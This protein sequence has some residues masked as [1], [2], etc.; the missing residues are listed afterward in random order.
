MRF[1]HPLLGSLAYGGAPADERRRAHGALAAS[2]T[3]GQGTESERRAWH[4]AAATL[5]PDEHVAGALAAAAERFAHRSGHLAAAY[6]YE[7]AAQLT[8]DPALRGAAADRGGR[9]RAA[10]RQPGP[11]ARAAA[12]RG[13]ARGRPVLR[14]DIAFKQAMV[15]A[16]LGS[17]ALAAE[18]YAQ[19]AEQVIAHDADRGA[20]WLAHAA[21]AAVAAGDTGSA[22]ASARRAATLLDHGQ[23]SERTAC[24]VRETL[25]TVLVLRGDPREGAPLLRAAADWFERRGELPGRDYVS[26][27]LLWIEDYALARRCLEPL[28]ASRAA[29]RRPALADLGA[30]D[31]GPA[32]VPRRRL[33]GRARRRGGVGAPGARYRP[34]GPARLQP[35]RARDRRGRARGSR[36]SR[37]CRRGR[38]D[39]RRATGSR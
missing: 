21:G 22:L 37:A 28:L 33:A 14:A 23:L 18:R 39:R 38:R 25:G 16:W 10:G 9:G 12:D 26:Q 11:F 3:A 32:R 4:L 15:E 20:L 6:A 34:D 13:D 24:T 36:R 7:R 19:L 30:R 31:P 29:D 1:R 5:A 17:V 8:P 27:S 2:L 35:R